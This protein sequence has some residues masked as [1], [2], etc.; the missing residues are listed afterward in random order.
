MSDTGLGV[1]V[2]AAASF[3]SRL[4]RAARSIG[5]ITATVTIEE[6]H[7]DDLDITDHPVEQGASISDHA[8]KRPAEVTIKCG[9]SNSPSIP[10]EL[11][12]PAAGILSRAPQLLGQLNEAA[13]AGLTAISSQVNT[14]TGEGT[15]TVQDVYQRL[16]ELQASAVPFDIYTGKRVYRSMLIK[17]ISVE[18]DKT[19]ENALLATLI[20]RQVIIV[21]TSVVTVGAA[22]DR[23]A[24]PGSTAP[25]QDS[26]TK[27]VV[28]VDPEAN[29]PLKYLL[30]VSFPVN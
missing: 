10:G 12:G 24:S 22:A 14:G 8:Y 19:T 18:T 20:C 25:T 28:P 29:A 9:W 7:Q 6:R 21:Q 5:P 1:V 23:Q 26:G 16:L 13:S 4:S 15:S 2:A 27:Q 17:S 11:L 3:G 30:A